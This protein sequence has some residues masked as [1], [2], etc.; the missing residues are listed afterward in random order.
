[1][2]SCAIM[3]LWHSDYVYPNNLLT[4]KQGAEPLNREQGAEGQEVH[5]AEQRSAGQGR[6]API[7]AGRDAHYV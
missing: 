6:G 7:R 5:S 2:S 3:A 1:M 4:M